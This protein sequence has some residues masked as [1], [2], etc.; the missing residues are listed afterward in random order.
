MNFISCRKCGRRDLR[1][2]C[3]YSRSLII[4]FLLIICMVGCV[5]R[6]RRWNV[7][8]ANGKQYKNLIYVDRTDG[9][10]EFEDLGGKSYVFSGNYTISED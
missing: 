3:S 7:T 5:D 6:T 2:N 1:C 4:V 10:I 8:D 9:I